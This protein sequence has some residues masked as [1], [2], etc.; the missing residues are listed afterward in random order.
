[1]KIL[2]LYLPVWCAGYEKFLSK[3]LDAEKIFILGRSITHEF[4]SFQKDLRALEPSEAQDL[5]KWKFPEKDIFVF[6]NEDNPFEGVT[7]IVMPDDDIS[8]YLLKRIPPHIEVL[9]DNS[10][11]LR[12]DS[13]NAKKCKKVESAE[14]ISATTFFREMDARLDEEAQ[15]SP[16]L[17]R[18]IAGVIFDD[19]GALLLRHN[20]CVPSFEELFFVGDPRGQFQKGVNVE[21]SIFLHVEAGLI[22]QAANLGICLKDKSMYVTTFPCPPCGKLI[23]FSGIK[24]LFFKEGY[25]MLDSEEV[26]KYRGVEIFQIQ[27]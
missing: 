21:L 1:M 7:T 15:K 20:Q 14:V 9:F 19:S 27:F 26:L 4:R 12:W 13:D 3:H 17:Y 2:I 10:I 22:A 11:F 16:D 5:L 23:A 6:E 8:H 24:K 25:A 18:Q